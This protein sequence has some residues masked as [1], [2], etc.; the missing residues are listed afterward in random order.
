MTVEPA[1]LSC[2][3]AVDPPARFVPTGQFRGDVGQFDYV[4]EEWFATGEADGH[5]YATAMT[6][7][8]PRDRERFSGLVIVEPVHAASAAPIWIYTSS[9]Q[10]RSGHG[11]AAVCS[12][13]SVLDTFVKPANPDRYAALE[14]WSDAPSLEAEGLNP[15][16]VPREPAAFQARM[17]HMRKINVLSTPILAQVGA[18]LAGPAGPFAGFDVRQLIL[19]GHSQT[20]GVVT[21]Y[22]LN[23]HDVVRLDNGSPV[24]QGFFPTG[25]P[26]VQFG[27]RDAPILQVLSDGD[28][29]NP[30]RPGRQ[31]R[32]YRR[33]DSDDPGDGY[34]LY[35]LAGV[36]HMGTRYPPYSDNAM[37]Q[38][39][40]L[41]TAGSVPKG[42]PM[43]SLPHGELFSMAL[44]HL[45][46][47]V[48]RGV[49]PPRADRIEVGPDGLFAKDEFGNSRGG[50]RCVQM[51]VPRLRYLPNPGVDE[52]GAP[53]FGVVGIEEPLTEEQLKGL[54]RDHDD[55][56]ERFNH[57]LDELIAQGWFL[58]EDAAEMRA[59]AVNAA[60]P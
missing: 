34:R 1:T 51:D 37:W 58:V 41:G 32:V 31:G 24:Y 5:Q 12:Q 2:P 60:V 7:R 21:D 59:E 57:R 15:I 55:Y 10:L 52:S 8:R 6:V 33:E 36:S 11:W 16:S 54:Y 49:V 53:A 48:S 43:N 19:A 40:P 22:I 4:E 29:S 3:A 28:I 18:A 38:N 30:N 25:A 56:V 17:E 39:D 46:Q 14:I 45:A 20:G 23:A 35:E 9:Y 27:P 13:K 50:V 26:S 42:A 44:D 47:W